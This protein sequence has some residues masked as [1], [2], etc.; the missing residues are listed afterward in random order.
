[1]ASFHNDSGHFLF[2]ERLI[3]FVN[4]GVFELI[5]VLIGL[6]VVSLELV[7]VLL[8]KLVKDSFASIVVIAHP[9]HL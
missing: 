3:L 4:G 5:V 6:S 7:G 2:E 9:K 1:M 8:G